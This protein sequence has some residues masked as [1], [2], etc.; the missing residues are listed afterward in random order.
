MCL[1]DFPRP[2][3]LASKMQDTKQQVPQLSGGFFF[4]TCR[5]DFKNA[6]FKTASSTSAWWIFP[7]HVDLAL[8]YRSKLVS[9]TCDLWI[10][11]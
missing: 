9:F 10:F 2:V 6:G 8:E 11:Q 5:F 3:D 1:V 4:M 7:R